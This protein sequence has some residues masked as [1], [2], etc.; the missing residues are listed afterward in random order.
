MGLSAAVAM[1]DETSRSG[2]DTRTVRAP[3]SS[4]A[5]GDAASG[6]GNSSSRPPTAPP[7]IAPDTALP[8]GQSTDGCVAS[9][10]KWH[11]HTA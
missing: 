9:E 6:P 5:N 2:S 4:Y 8:A 10:L 1:L 7:I 3:S 11:E